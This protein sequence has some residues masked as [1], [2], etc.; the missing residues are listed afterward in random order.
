MARFPPPGE[1]PPTAPNGA[2]PHGQLV[3]AALAWHDVARLG[4]PATGAGPLAELAGRID[5]DLIPTCAADAA[6]L[7]ASDA[8]ALESVATSFEQM[9]ALLFAA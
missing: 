1:S 9:G 2:R 7:A 6:A 3:F 8:A 5:G 4:D